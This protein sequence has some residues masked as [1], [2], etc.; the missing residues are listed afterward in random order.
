VACARAVSA[1]A[2]AHGCT[3]KGTDQV[4]FELA[5]QA[6]APDLTVI[7][8]W[9]SWDIVS[10]E[11]ALRYAASRGIPVQQTAKDLYSRDANL[12]HISHEGGPLEDPARAPEEAM[13]RL[14]AGPADPTTR[15]GPSASSC[16]SRPARRSGWT[17]A[18]SRRSSWSSGSTRSPGAT[19]SAGP[20][21]SRAGWWG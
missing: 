12:W 17:A 21:W 16:A 1:D 15:R 7:A 18:S 5:Y 4:R 11:D 3:G 6:L 20:T 9:R 13:F 14:T 8:P 10:R 2:L 19:A